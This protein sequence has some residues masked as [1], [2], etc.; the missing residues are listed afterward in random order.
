MSQRDYIPLNVRLAAALCLIGEIPHEDAKRMHPDQVIGLFQFDHYPIGH[1]DGG[2]DA[3]WNLMPR[4]I[5]PHRKKSARDNT[6]RAKGRRIIRA[7]AEHATRM[8]AKVGL[9]VENSARTPRPKH[10]IRSRG[11]TGW[12]RF[13]GEIVR[14]GEKRT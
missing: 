13:N 8:A 9:P 7:N 3:H 4:L 10:K 12:R 11:F 1:G 5:I 14:R 2:P 6:E